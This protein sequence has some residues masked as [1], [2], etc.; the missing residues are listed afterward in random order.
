MFKGYSV[1]ANSEFNHYCAYQMISTDFLSG[2]A[3]AGTSLTIT[4]AF[5]EYINNGTVGA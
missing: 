1:A 2:L 4:I 5:E 3:S